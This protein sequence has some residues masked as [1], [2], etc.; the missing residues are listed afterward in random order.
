MKNTGSKLQK[1][2]HYKKHKLINWLTKMFFCIHIH[3]YA[4]CTISA[5]LE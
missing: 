2:Y 3:A 5:M 1:L 4:V